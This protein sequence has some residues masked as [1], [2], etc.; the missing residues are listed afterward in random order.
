[1]TD[2]MERFGRLERSL[3]KVRSNKNRKVDEYKDDVLAFFEV[4][5]SLKDWIRNSQQIAESATKEAEKYAKGNISL[6]ICADI[7]NRSKHLKL[8]FKREDADIHK[9]NTIIHAAPPGKG[10]GEL[11]FQIRLDSG[12]EFDAISTAHVVTKVWQIFLLH[13]RVY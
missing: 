2:V 13:H 3:E 11:R 5:W 4:G 9:R 10:Y 6:R 1:M 8:T 7:A 12:H